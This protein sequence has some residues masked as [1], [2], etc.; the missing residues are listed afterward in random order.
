M[1]E[2]LC[3][4]IDTKATKLVLLYTEK[5]DL[6]FKLAQK[7]IETDPIHFDKNPEYQTLCEEEREAR[8]RVKLLEDIE[9]CMQTIRFL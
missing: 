2:A 7:L 9:A 1:L 3:E 4:A 6:R 8:R 5:R